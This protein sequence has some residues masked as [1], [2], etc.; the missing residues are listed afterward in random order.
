LVLSQVVRHRTRE[1]PEVRQ[2]LILREAILLVGER[3]CNGFTVEELAKRCGIS[4]GGLLHHFETK[5]ALLLSI[6]DELERS[7]AEALSPLAGRALDHAGGGP[8]R[9]AVLAFLAAAFR[10]SNHD[11]DMGRLYVRLTAEAVDPA[12]LA[13]ASMRRRETATIALFT[14]LFSPFSPNPQGLARRAMAL[15]HGLTLQS[16][17][18]KTPF[19]PAAE[20]MEAVEQMLPEGPVRD[21]G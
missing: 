19:D 5:E 10:G 11:P 6:I 14:R 20:W 17:L 16:L 18:G 1:N 7:E 13:H 15:L 8:S 4:K 3:G 21:T 12:H 9:E 2:R